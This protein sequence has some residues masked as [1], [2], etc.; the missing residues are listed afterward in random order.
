VPADDAH[1]SEAE[2]DAEIEA[3]FR[4]TVAA[5]RAAGKRKRGE[6]LVAF[7]WA[8]LVDVSRLTEGKAA[9]LVAAYI[10]RR[11]HVCNSRT[12]TLP[13]NE[14]AELGIDR[15]RKSEALAKLAKPKLIKIE[16]TKAGQST[17]VTL[18]WRPT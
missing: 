5:T 11:V 17:K 10:Y 15:R 16:K 2:W 3:D 18:K 9:V 4:R 13:G 14:L 12:V 6:R 1:K 7:P 8:F